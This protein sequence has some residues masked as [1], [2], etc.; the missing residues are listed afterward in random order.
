MSHELK[1]LELTLKLSKMNIIELMQVKR[2]TDDPRFWY[3]L[4]K[5]IESKLTK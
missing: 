2:A 1:A 4:D 5:I 3:I